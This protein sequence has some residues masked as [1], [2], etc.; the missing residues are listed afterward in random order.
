MARQG[1]VIQ[2]KGGGSSVRS[3]GGFY[4]AQRSRIGNYCT[5]CDLPNGEDSV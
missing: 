4:T 5:V 2:M 3:K 1:A